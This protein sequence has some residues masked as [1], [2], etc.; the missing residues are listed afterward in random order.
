MSG[1]A[2]VLEAVA[3]IAALALPVRLR[4][5]DR[6]DREPA[7]GRAMKPGDI[8]TRHDRHDD[9]GQQHRR[10]GPARACRLPAPRGRARRRALVDLAT[11]T[12]A[13]RHRARA[14]PTPGC[15][16]TT[17]TWA[18]AVLAA[19]ERDAGELVWRMP[20]HAEYDELIKGRYA[21]IVNSP[22]AAQG[23]L[24]HRRR[25]PARASPA[26]CRGRTSTSP[27]PATTT[28]AP[29]RP[30]AASGCGVR[31]LVELARARADPRLQPF[32]VAG[33]EPAGAAPGGLPARARA[34]DAPVSKRRPA[35]SMETWPP[36]A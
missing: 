29:T 9:R 21:D 12:G 19:G 23:A 17:T 2:A 6:R 11:L 33:D 34:A 13:H 8:V 15:S 4:R 28:G 32:G 30:R 24:D 27:A 14:R 3:A 16:P 36:L 18:A 26:T 22:R 35:T 25:V 20:L 5:R 1:G 31:L 10:R 7:G